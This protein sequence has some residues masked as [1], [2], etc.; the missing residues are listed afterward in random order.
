M[1]HL[2][3]VDNGNKCHKAL[4]RNEES[5]ICYSTGYIESE[6]EPISKEN[7]LI[8]NGKFYS[9]GTGRF[10]TIFNKAQ[11][12]RSFIL[13]LPAVGN[14]LGEQYTS[15]T[16]NIILAVGLP[17]AT[18]GKLKEEFRRYFLRDNI[19]FCWN[20][21][22]YKVNIK[23]CLVFPQGYSAF[24]TIY[25]DFKDIQVLCCDIGGY[26]V[27]IFNVNKGGKLD[28]ASAIS[29]NRGVIKLFRNIQQELIK[30]DIR[31]T[32]EQIEE[33]LKGSNPVM[34]DE[35]IVSLINSKAKQYTENLIDELREFGYETR[36][37][38]IIFVGGGAMLL[39]RFIEQSNKVGYVEFLDQY[40]NCRGYQLLARKALSMKGE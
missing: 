6:F 11:D 23:D 30:Q 18:F 38:P 12:E 35:T 19:N 3:C 24:L 4:G 27:D 9:I 16:T 31:I 14:Y 1:K 10:S 21:K 5:N 29:L 37:N 13:T 33:V 39:K 22:E 8:Y 36:I 15:D 26:T 20:G 28:I 34:L 25:N 40:A 17:I 7:L 2:I 32:E